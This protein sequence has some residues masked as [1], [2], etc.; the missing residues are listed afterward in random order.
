MG[1]W[2]RHVVAAAAVVGAS[3][4]LAGEGEATPTIIILPY[5]K[6]QVTVPVG[7]TVK[8][9]CKGDVD[10]ISVCDG[11]GCTQLASYACVPY[12]CAKNGVECTS[13]C[14]SNAD[15]GQGAECN[16]A[17]GECASYFGT[18]EDART[19]KSPA[20]SLSSCAPYRCVAGAC[21]Q[22]CSVDIPGDCAAGWSCVRS[23][24]SHRYYCKKGG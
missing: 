8:T 7:K 9:S 15:C 4:A 10:V 24:T 22:Q 1:A 2:K 14:T 6:G 13:H 12:T 21:Q 16:T 18:C 11:A 19:V 3:V 5:W 23:A 20:G 17:R